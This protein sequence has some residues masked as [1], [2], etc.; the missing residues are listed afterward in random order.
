MGIAT[1]PDGYLKLFPGQVRAPDV[2]FVRRQRL[3]DGR[4]PRDPIPALAPSLAIEVLSP[5]N[6]RREMQR[7]LRDYFAAGVE[8]VWYIDPRTQSATVYTGPE[9]YTEIG[10]DGV[11]GGGDILPGFKLSL[12]RLFS[13][14]E[15]L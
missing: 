13:E 1:G 6:T 14:S 8:L 9:Q 10:P 12:R 15:N 3:P 4:V 11:L 7:K 2:A 5:S